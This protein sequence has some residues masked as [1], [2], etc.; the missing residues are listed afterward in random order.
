MT[1]FITSCATGDYDQIE[2]Q[3]SQETEQEIQQEEVIQEEAGDSEISS[4]EAVAETEEMQEVM[5]EP[6]TESSSESLA[7]ELDKLS[8]PDGTDD[9]MQTDDSMVNMVTENETTMDSG[10][11]T[12]DSYSA[13][14]QLLMENKKT[15]LCSQETLSD[16]SHTSFMEALVAGENWQR[17]TALTILVASFQVT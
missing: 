10:M 11:E 6:V 17:T 1:A 14:P 12:T 7:S 13:P 8:T 4:E 2:E 15:M 9:T 5:Q 3:M 16:T